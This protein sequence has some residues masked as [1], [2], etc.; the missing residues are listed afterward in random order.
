MIFDLLYNISINRILEKD[1]D[2]HWKTVGSPSNLSRRSIEIARLLV[3]FSDRK[4]QL[5]SGN[6]PS[7]VLLPSSTSPSSSNQSILSHPNIRHPIIVHQQTSSSALPF[8]SVIV[9]PYRDSIQQALSTTTVTNTTDVKPILI[10]SVGII[11]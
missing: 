10:Q 2:D 9:K 11:S 8:R 5:M 7:I 4:R 1:I 6:P 3:H